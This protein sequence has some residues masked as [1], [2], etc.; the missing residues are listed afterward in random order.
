MTRRNPLWRL[1]ALLFAL[2][3]VAAACGD[4]DDDPSDEA[5]TDETEE[6]ADEE[7]EPAEED[8]E[9]SDCPPETEGDGQL[10]LGTLLPET[11]NLA[12]LGPPEFA[13][14]D[15]AVQ[16]INEAG[17]VL[18]QDVTSSRGDSG[19]T[20]TDIANQTAD[21]L[22]G[23][24]VDA[25][26]G[27][28]SS[29][30]TFTVIDKIT[31]ACTI[32][33]SPANTAPD[34]SEYDDNGLYWRTAPSDV[35]QGRVL[36]EVVINDGHTTVGILALQDPYG[37]GL[38][39]NATTSITDSGGEVV[40]TVIYDPQA[41]TFDA[42][43]QQIVAADPEAIILIGFDESARVITALAEAGM[44]PQEKPLYLV[45]GNTGNALGEQLPAGLLE[46][47]KGTIPG[48]ASAQEFKDRLLAIDPALT[49]YSYAGESYDAVM[50]TALAAIAAG[51]DSGPAIASQLQAVSTEGEK[52]TTFADCLALL[53]A[54]EDI[55]YDGIS[56]PVEFDENGD[57]TEASIGVYTFQADNTLSSEVEYVFGQV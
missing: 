27:A 14:V 12:F 49:D 57:P 39:E 53:E 10:K 37:E 24:S 21:R 47:V 3:L 17:G 51:N 34:L 19:D 2:S 15:L 56:G 54:G 22:L 32:Q 50:L 55:D 18:D 20:S 23:E 13:G 16:E 41:Q 11:G 35:L 6:P 28:A 33:F 42:E 31:G 1:L 43:V 36:G 40:Q 38:A 9:A 52:C 4:D 44:G 26:I 7:E 29:G 5:A 30:V 25:I 48:S 45:D 46:G 8:T